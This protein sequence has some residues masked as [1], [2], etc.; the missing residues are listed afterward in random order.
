M[1]APYCGPLW[2]YFLN[3]KR[4]EKSEKIWPWLKM[5]GAKNK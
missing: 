3:E 2:G 5:D 1:V 4:E